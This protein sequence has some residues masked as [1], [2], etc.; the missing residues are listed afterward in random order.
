MR[1]IFSL[2]VAL[3]GFSA[4]AF[5]ADRQIAFERDNAIYVANLD[6]RRKR[7]LNLSHVC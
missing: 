4:T 3:A 7:L 6:D 5:S 1:K 2:V